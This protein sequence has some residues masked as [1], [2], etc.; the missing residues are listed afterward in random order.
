MAYVI[1]KKK[2]EIKP[3]ADDEWLSAAWIFDMPRGIKRVAL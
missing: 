1:L 2:K 3:T